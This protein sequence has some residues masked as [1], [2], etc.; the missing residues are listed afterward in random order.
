MAS[1]WLIER[2]GIYGFASVDTRL[3]LYRIQRSSAQVD[4][5]IAFGEIYQISDSTLSTEAV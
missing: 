4:S 2:S 3:L 5:Y 1:I